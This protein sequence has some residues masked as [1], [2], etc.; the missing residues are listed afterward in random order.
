MM[1]CQNSKIVSHAHTINVKLAQI[2][3]PAK[4]VLMIK[5]KT[6]HAFCLTALARL[7]SIQISHN[8]LT[9]NVSNY[10]NKH[11]Y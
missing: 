8:R 6:I 7:T 1:R 3:H 11:N 2:T 9:A 5:V 4:P 10:I